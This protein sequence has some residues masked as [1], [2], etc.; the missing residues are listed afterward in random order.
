MNFIFTLVQKGDYISAVL[1]RNLTENITRVLYPNDNV[2]LTVIKTRLK[3][4]LSCSTAFLP[5]I[6]FH[7]ESMQSSDLQC[8]ANQ[9]AGFYMKCDTRQ[10]WV[11]AL[12]LCSG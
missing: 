3:F 12:F 4:R 5:S 11:N 7:I 10:K 6:A 2:R 9:K 8:S 1:D